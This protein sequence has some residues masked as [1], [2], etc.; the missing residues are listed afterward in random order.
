MTSHLPTGTISFLFTD[1]AN[2][3]QLWDGHPA[4]NQTALAGHDTLPR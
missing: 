1:L 3:I 4:A 2:S